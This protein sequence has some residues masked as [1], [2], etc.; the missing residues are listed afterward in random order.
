MN[1]ENLL[2]LIQKKKATALVVDESGKLKRFSEKDGAE[3]TNFFIVLHNEKGYINLGNAPLYHKTVTNPELV[4]VE[5]RKGV[6]FAENESEV[7]ECEFQKDSIDYYLSFIALCDRMELTYMC[8]RMRKPLR[9]SIPD[10]KDFLLWLRLIVNLLRAH[11]QTIS[12]NL[13]DIISQKEEELFD[14]QKEEKEE[15]A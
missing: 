4:S 1:Q 13:S 2:K 15:K 12:D 11:N 10:N 8:P 9:L 3:T 6:Y 7:K 14:E 5:C